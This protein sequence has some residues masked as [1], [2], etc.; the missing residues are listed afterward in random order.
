MITIIFH[1]LPL[2]LQL[3]TF[4]LLHIPKYAF[5]NLNVDDVPRSC[6]DC[7]LCLFLSLPEK[8]ETRAICFFKILSHFLC[9]H[10]NIVR[11]QKPYVY[12]LTIL[13]LLLFPMNNRTEISV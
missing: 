13:I 8:L 3:F 2:R 12:D 7:V 4:A 6:D 1:T 5:F 11:S 10:V 9:S